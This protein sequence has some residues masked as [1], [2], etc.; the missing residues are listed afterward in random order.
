MLYL[1]RNNRMELLLEALGDV[2]AV[3]RQNV[4][5]PELIVVQSQ[6]MER[7]LSMGLAERFGV[8]CN[9]AHPFPRA[10][11]E[12]ISD[13]VIGPL[14]EAARYTRE[15]MALHLATI[16]GEL[17]ADD[18]LEPLRRYLEARPGVESRLQLAEQLADAFDQAQIY[19]PDWC[20]AWARGV[21]AREGSTPEASEQS[22]F[23]PVL[24]RL[25]M[26]RLG[27][28]HFPAQIARLSEALEHRDFHPAELPERVSLFGVAT[29]PP[30]FLRVFA[31]LAR[32]VPVHWFLLTATREYVGA[33]RDRREL[34]RTG[35]DRATGT[36]V[37]AFEQQ[38]ESGQ[39]L[40][41]NY[42]RIMRDVGLLLERDCQYVEGQARAYVEPEPGSVLGTLQADLCALRRRGVSADVPRLPFPE[43]D[44]SLQVHACHGPRRELEVLRQLLLDAFER[45]PTLRPE[46]VIVLLRDVETYAPLVDAVFA[47][48]RGHPGHIPYRVSDRNL[49]ATNPIVEAV[50]VLLETVQGRMSVPAL[51]RL[52]EFAPIAARFGLDSQQRTR[53]HQWLRQLNVTWGV[54]MAD[55]QRE[56]ALG[57]PEHTLRWGLSR[58]LL[59]V[60]MVNSPLSRW[61]GLSPVDVEGDDAE[62]AATFVECAQA[63]FAWRE[64]FAIARSFADWH[65]AVG[66]AVKELLR[67]EAADAWQLADLLQT[68]A[69]LGDEAER[70]RF[71]EPVSA[72]V[73]A[74]KLRSHYENARS[75]QT[76]LAGGV[77]FCAML[78]MRGIPA[79]I[80]AMVGLDDGSFPRAPTR[81]SFDDVA[82]SPTRPGDRAGRDEDR[83]LFLETLLAARE[84]LIIT[85]QGR[86]PRDDTPRPRSVVVD[87]LLAVIDESFACRDASSSKPSERLTV[88][89]PLH[90]HSARY[91][92]GSD[93][94]LVLRDAR[95]YR[96]A[97]VVEASAFTLDQGMTEAL[98]PVTQTELELAD[99]ELFWSAPARYFFERRLGAFLQ[100]EEPGIEQLDPTELDGLGRY[101]L[102]LMQ[103]QAVSD[104]IDEEDALADWTAQGR[105]PFANLGKIVHDEQLVLTRNLRAAMQHIGV[106]GPPRDVELSVNVAGVELVGTLVDVYDVGR[107]DWSP[108]RISAKHRLVAWL[109][110][111]SL[112]AAGQR[113]ATWLLRSGEKSDGELTI[114]RLP[115]FA[116]D[117]ALAHLGAFVT[118]FQ[119]GQRAPLAFFPKI[120][121]DYARR[122]SRGDPRPAS[123]ERAQRDF[124][125]PLA[126]EEDEYRT[127]P[128]PREVMRLFGGQAPLGDIWPNRFGIEGFPDFG[129]LSEK[130]FLPYLAYVEAIEL[131]PGVAPHVR[132]TPTTR[133]RS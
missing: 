62:L 130:T 120:S 50:A 48:D 16:L 114:E 102:A 128:G 133:G 24:F 39:P 122:I 49:G 54:D 28:R 14:D 131:D 57:Q 72:A 97:L 13:R 18:R 85:Y 93:D 11:I 98:D 82:R 84:R 118:S 47:A 22:D 56:G 79:R 60:A 6:G 117:A 77:T 126:Q 71:V 68:T 2:L 31:A 69:A 101:Q 99:L 110:H 26:A 4:F 59:G 70:A 115:A 7:W 10:F 87:E 42:G 92:D 96:A 104:G 64:R 27:E 80:V 112:A 51:L 90:A 19:R 17:P 91:F 81:S 46:D 15:A 66:E 37:A 34:A 83:H 100:P 40:L 35:R 73:V 36:D 30:A 61:H 103:W 21:S 107:V 43:D 119:L 123:L 3:P 88:V 45:D 12:A 111:L 116:A 124:G 55:R 44:R 41:A 29:L 105:R 52:L 8:W 132:A 129:Q 38:W 33:E 63:I 108:A 74:R 20:V 78:P 95:Q 67:V 25:M 113:C 125:D 23:R 65:V 86:N 109:R 1:H 75:A 127:P 106:H 5:Q 94:R 9:A 76:L 32:H 58:L 53:I 121:W 89:H